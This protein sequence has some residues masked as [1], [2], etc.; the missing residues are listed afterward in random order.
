M[1]SIF[2][3]HRDLRIIDNLSLNALS[4]YSKD[5]I[6]IFI[7]TPEQVSKQNEY[8]N[9]NSIQFMIESIENLRR[10]TKNH[11]LVFYGKTETV[12]ETIL[13]QNKDISFI[14]YNSDY[15]RYAK[16]RDKKIKH[17]ST[18]YGVKVITHQDY[19]LLDMEEVRGDDYYSV[20]KPYY[21]RVIKVYNDKEKKREKEK[22][23]KIKFSENLKLKNLKIVK[24]IKNLNLYTQ[25]DHLLVK[26]NRK[27]ALSILKNILKNKN[28]NYNK[29]RNIPSTNTTHLSAH[30]KF[31]TVSIREVYSY[32]NKLGKNNELVR[33]LIWHDFY[34][35]LMYYLPYR[36]T[37]GGGNFKKKNVKWKN[38]KK[39]FKKWC[40]GKT[41]FPIVDAGMRQ[42]NK[43]GWVHNRVRL[44]TSNFL[45]LILGIDWRKG[46]KYYAQKL[47]DYDPSS[48]NGNWQFSAQVGIDRVPYLRMYNPFKQAKEF[49]KDCKYIKEWVEE[50]RHVDNKD[51]LNWD[52]ACI[53]NKNKNKYE[54][55][56]VDLAEKMKEAK[57]RYNYNV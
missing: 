38:S 18:K 44:I 22:K 55:P 42:L 26:G 4:N 28:N 47:V 50:L 40:E 43:I 15:T 30:I 49:D 39:Y 23:K 34:A 13:K 54:C 1:K 35:Q 19:T 3:F 36:Q 17:I 46:E 52:K 33:Q 5:I 2:L 45:V 53:N 12:I 29:T 8:Y 56:I 14:G 27:Q 48:N 51:I 6:P 37:L 31:G 25:N 10:M 11:L 16:Q 21:N 57:I 41:G 32:F 7:L 24:N 9:S 20:F